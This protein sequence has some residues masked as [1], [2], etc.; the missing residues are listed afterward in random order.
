MHHG[1]VISFIFYGQLTC[2]ASSWTHDWTPFDTLDISYALGANSCDVWENHDDQIFSHRACR[3]TCEHQLRQ[4]GLTN[5]STNHGCLALPNW[6][7]KEEKYYSV[8]TLTN[9]LN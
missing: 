9:K 2:A 8:N 5:P 6:P 7:L 1:K 3:Q 4:W